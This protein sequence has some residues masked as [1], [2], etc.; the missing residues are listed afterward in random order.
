MYRLINVCNMDAIFFQFIFLI[1]FQLQ[2]VPIKPDAYDK[3]MGISQNTDIK[4][5]PN[6]FFAT[7]SLLFSCF[8]QLALQLNTEASIPSTTIYI[9]KWLAPFSN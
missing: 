4:I 7:V 2:F 6:I 9:G 3:I 8:D 1:C 5:L